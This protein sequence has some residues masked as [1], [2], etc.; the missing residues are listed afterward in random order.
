MCGLF[1][2]FLFF[3]FNCLINTFVICVTKAG[4]WSGRICDRVYRC[5]V[6]DTVWF[7]CFESWCRKSN[8]YFFRLPFFFLNCISLRNICIC[9]NDCARDS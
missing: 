5:L 7:L 8:I 2:L 1:F 6:F 4:R 9:L 3:G